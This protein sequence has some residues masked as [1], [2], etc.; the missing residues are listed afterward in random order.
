MPREKP[1]EH[2]EDQQLTQPRYGSYP[3]SKSS[4]SDWWEVS[5]LTLTIAIPASQSVWPALSTICMLGCP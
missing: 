1:L 3:Q 4:R 2:G 5:T